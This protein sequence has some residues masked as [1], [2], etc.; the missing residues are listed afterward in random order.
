M[1]KK[2]AILLYLFVII[3]VTA[4][5]PTVSS[6]YSQPNED[7][8]QYI[9]DLSKDISRIIPSPDPSILYNSNGE[10]K[11]KLLLS[12]WGE[13]K[14]VYVS[15]SS[16]N[17]DL[18]NLCL[19]TAWTYERYQ[20]FPEK[21]GEKDL[22]IDVPIIFDVDSSRLVQTPSAPGLARTISEYPGEKRQ[23][24]KIANLGLNSAV[25]IALENHMAAKIA[26]DEMEL[27]RLKIREAR[28]ALY[29]AASLNYAETTGKTTA[30]TQDFTDKEYKLKFEYP[31]YYGWKLR[32]AVEQAITSM[33][34]STSNY[35]KVLQDLRLEVE[36][37]FYSY[38]VSK[39]D[40][41]LQHKL[42]EDTEAIFSIA[43]K[44]FEAGL[45]T[46]AEFMQV[47]TQVQQINYQ[48]ISSENEL[49]IAKLALSQA[50]NM[51]SSEKALEI[52]DVDTEKDL[53]PVMVDVS[54]DECMDLAFKARPDLKMREYMKEFSD[55]ERKIVESKNQLKVD[56][57][58]TYGK[59]GGAYQSES[60]NMAD[61]W[62]LGFKVTKPLGGNTAAVT[63]TKDQTS[64]KH[65]QSTRT[66]SVSK[67]FE[68]GLLDNI[69]HFSEEKSAEIGFKKAQDELD[70]LKDSIFKEVKETFL[71]YKK[72][73]AQIATNINKVKYKEEELK[74]A[75]ARAEL[76]E[77]S[78]SELIQAHI[79]L[80]DERSYYLEA[81]G[82]LLQSLAKLNKATGFSLFI[83]DENFKLANVK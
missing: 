44:R 39:M 51:G 68:L 69:Q 4:I 38:M 79:S 45:I 32:Y 29:P 31:L 63:Y 36:L 78:L 8:I 2:H 48:I 82:S 71:G 52:I 35:D 49:T 9:T 64:Q 10:V 47:E 13:L 27:S 23:E 53:E 20:P 70:Q 3:I 42:Q 81:V 21:L 61:D 30:S 74:I 56:L 34:A 55:Y 67:A 28:R 26:Q 65:G 11:L 60:L 25:D 7:I 66:E 41:K 72:G 22:W 46:R 43:K 80:T 59:S 83:D 19:K 58:G 14:D 18:D 50:V 5:S 77:M 57:T 40:V 1:R 15:E 75:K 37:A 73:Q 17:P 12:P 6:I 16:G 54:L 76:N 62:Y 33:K 24:G